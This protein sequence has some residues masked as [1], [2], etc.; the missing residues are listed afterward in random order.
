MNENEEH[1]GNCDWH[2]VKS[3]NERLCLLNGKVYPGNHH[4]KHWR[5]YNHHNRVNKQKQAD[6]YMRRIQDMEIAEK[7][8]KADEKVRDEDKEVQ[9][10]DRK[11]QR[12]MAW[13]DQGR[14]LLESIARFFHP[15]A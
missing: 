5:T 7:R 10:E 4:C 12:K 14:K 13:I 3:Q 1:C 6:D 9:Q 2:I 8:S 11:F 15:G